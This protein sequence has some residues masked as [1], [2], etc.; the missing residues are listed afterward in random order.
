LCGI[1]AVFRG[2][3]PLPSNNLHESATR[4]RSDISTNEKKG[5]D[6]YRLEFFCRPNVLARISDAWPMRILLAG[7][8]E[9]NH[10]FAN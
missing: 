8:I 1:S 2:K 3:L 7:L 4:R 6:Y 9:A 5:A 10:P